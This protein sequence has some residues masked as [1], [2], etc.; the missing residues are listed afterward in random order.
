MSRGSIMT[1]K[2]KPIGVVAS[3]NVMD[4]QIGGNHY[5]KMKIQPMR[6]AMEN[7]LDALQFS[8]VKYVTRFRDKNGVAD[9]EKAKHCIDM[10]IQFEQKGNLE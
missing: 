10:L 4:V 2:A 6:F 1:G 8:V 3:A 5:K 9:L 7:T